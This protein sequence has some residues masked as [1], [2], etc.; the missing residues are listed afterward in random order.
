MDL[1]CSFGIHAI[2]LDSRDPSDGRWIAACSW[3]ENQN[4]Q[5]LGLVPYFDDGSPY[6]R[7]VVRTRSDRNHVVD[8][9]MHR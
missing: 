4:R 5:H 2:D 8:V 9:S 6:D 3:L 7:H 1:S